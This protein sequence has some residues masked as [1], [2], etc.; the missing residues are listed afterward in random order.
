MHLPTGDRVQYYHRQVTVMLVTGAPA[1][2]EPPRIPWE[3][4]PQLAGEDEVA[5][6]K[7]LPARVIARYPR[8]FDLV[9]ADALD[10]GADFF[11]FLLDRNKHTLVALNLKTAVHPRQPRPAPMFSPPRAVLRNHPLGEVRSSCAAQ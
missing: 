4:E 8:A 7:R 1:N 11:N 9:P 2:R 6:A 5:T 10:A 3:Y